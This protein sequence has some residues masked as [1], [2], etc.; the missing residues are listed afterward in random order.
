M[1]YIYV[2]GNVTCNCVGVG[3]PVHACVCVSK[4]IVYAII[5]P[6]CILHTWHH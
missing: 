2:L 1:V 5:A 4:R 6:E 3:V